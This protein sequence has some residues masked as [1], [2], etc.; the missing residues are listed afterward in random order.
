MHVATKKAPR[1]DWGRSDFALAPQLDLALALAQP[2]LGFVAAFLGF[3]MP[4]RARPK[5]EDER[6]GGERGGLGHLEQSFFQAQRPTP[7]SYPMRYICKSKIASST[8]S[9]VVQITGCRVRRCGQAPASTRRAM[10][11]CIQN[12]PWGNCLE[13]GWEWLSVGPVAGL[14]YSRILSRLR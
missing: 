10:P 9:P 7:K 5:R 11:S 2:L 13:A 3:P 14:A 8:C 4:G 6:G 1:R 12:G